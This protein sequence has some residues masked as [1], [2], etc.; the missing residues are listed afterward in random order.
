MTQGYSYEGL[1]RESE[2]RLRPDGRNVSNK[3]WLGRGQGEEEWWPTQ[4]APAPFIHLHMKKG[5]QN[6]RVLKGSVVRKLGV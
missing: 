6:P 3:W 2:G 5:E 4:V 1:R